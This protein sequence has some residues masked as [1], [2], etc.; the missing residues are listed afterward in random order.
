MRVSNRP[1]L[2]TKS[3][4]TRADILFNEF[5]KFSFKK[6]KFLNAYQIFLK[7]I[8]KHNFF[9]YKIII[10]YKSTR[11]TI[12][13]EFLWRK[14]DLLFALANGHQ[15]IVIVSCLELYSSNQSYI[16]TIGQDFILIFSLIFSLY[17]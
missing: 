13:R 15:P 8:L 12:F 2:N 7:A 17:H 1:E 10:I 5:N 9:F 4:L 3:T 6:K 11:H 16:F 14:T